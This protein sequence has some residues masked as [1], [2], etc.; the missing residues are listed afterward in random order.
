MM[1]IVCQWKDGR[2]MVKSAVLAD[3][4]RRGRGV[5]GKALKLLLY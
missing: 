2:E 3:G 5:V 1:E 4:Q